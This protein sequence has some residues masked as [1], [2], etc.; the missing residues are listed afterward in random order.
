MAPVLSIDMLRACSRPCAGES[1][2]TDSTRLAALLQLGK[3][4]II[5]DTPVKHTRPVGGPNYLS[6][7]RPA[8][9]R[10]TRTGY[11]SRR[12]FVESRP[13]STSLRRPAAQRR[14]DLHRPDRAEIDAVLMA[15]IDSCS[16]PPARRRCRHALPRRT[17]SRTGPG[18][19]H[20]PP[21]YPRAMLALAMDRL[22]KIPGIRFLRPQARARAGPAATVI[23]QSSAV[24]EAS[25]LPRRLFPRRVARIS[26]PRSARRSTGSS[27][28]CSA[29]P[30]TTAASR[31]STIACGHRRALAQA[32]AHRGP[33]AR[34]QRRGAAQ[35]RASSTW[36]APAAPSPRCRAWHRSRARSSSSAARHFG[37]NLKYAWLERS[38][39]A[40]DAGYECW[41]L[42]PDAQQQALVE[43]L[44]APCLPWSDRDWTPEHFLVAQRTAVLVV[45]DHFFSAAYH[46]NPY[47]PALLAGARWVQLWHGISI[48][49]I[50]AALP[51]A[52]ARHVGVSPSRWPRAALH[53][54]GRRRSGCRGRMAA[55]VLF[56]RYAPSAIRAT[57]CCCASRPSATC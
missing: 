9:R 23:E 52:A 17:T 13:T 44:G 30:C 51:T 43:S 19:Q 21:R 56:E 53:E 34:P 22:F 12:R 4:A 29:L 2:A 40:G 20:G 10:R 39:H 24:L 46:P 57:T 32:R 33:I 15:L 37:D 54:F 45:A 1:A 7:S 55:L 31:R 6:A 50:G 41:Y 26:G 11:V 5:D 14:A 35:W 16:G 3:V 25:P 49:E 47:A 18:R 38:R 27:A 36:N 48:K 42:P 8:W 28:A